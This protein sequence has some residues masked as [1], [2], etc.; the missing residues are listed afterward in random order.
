M[1][2]NEQQRSSN[3]EQRQPESTEAADGVLAPATPGAENL[4]S[5]DGP[6]AT[7][8]SGSP[9]EDV[10]APATPGAEILGTPEDESGETR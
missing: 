8:G 6:A 2:S 10:L 5:P 9:D 7:D 3:E 1:S 4:G